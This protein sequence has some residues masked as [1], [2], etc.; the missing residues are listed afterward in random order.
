[1]CARYQGY[2]EGAEARLRA[3]HEC[4]MQ[5]AKEGQRLPRSLGLTRAGARL[6]KRLRE[7][8]PEPTSLAQAGR[9]E[10]WKEPSEPPVL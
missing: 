3:A 4:L 1:S 6:P 9:L 10:A 5:R 2:W 8:T 7:P